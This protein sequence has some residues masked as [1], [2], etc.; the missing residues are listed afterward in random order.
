MSSSVGRRA[1]RLFR[2]GISTLTFALAGL[3]AASIPSLAQTYSVLYSFPGGTEGAFPF[4]TITRDHK[5]NIYGTT[6]N[7]DGANGGTG[8]GVIYKI[9]AAGVETVM[10]PFEGP[11]GDGANPKG[12]AIHN[13]GLYGTTTSGGSSH[14][15]SG[16]CGVV[17]MVRNGE[18]V[19]HDF[20]GGAR[21]GAA[22][23][24]DLALDR[25]F[26]LYGATEFG[27]DKEC[28]AQGCGVIYRVMLTGKF[29]IGHIFTGPDGKFPLAGLL[30][31][32][33]IVYGTTSAG[34]A[35]GK[36]TVFS[37]DSHKRFKTLYEFKGGADG[38]DPE[39]PLVE[40]VNGNLYGTTFQGGGS[41][42]CPG[43]CGT[44]YEID[45]AGN[46]SVI[47]SFKGGADGANPR[48]TIVIFGQGVYGVTN[49]GGQGNPGY[50]VIFEVK[51]NGS[52]TVIHRFAGGADGENPFGG[53]QKDVH[54]NLY[55]TTVYGGDMSCGTHGCGLVFTVQQ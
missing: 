13:T 34:G 55:G 30:L 51:A 1:F 27:G 8:F 46:E 26:N 10:H 50:G 21:D 52:E 40:D 42:N 22:P 43:G 53:L 3:L 24:G 25:S 20:T 44:V 6:Y 11:P 7:T 36:G 5:G 49:A 9:S 2:S 54:G 39:G 33:T 48:G 32:G 12:G 38:S 15:C 18:V 29:N 23:V 14:N 17:F 19:I 41:A 28:S 35:S 31:S 47:Y 4:G 16:G 45:T 37:I